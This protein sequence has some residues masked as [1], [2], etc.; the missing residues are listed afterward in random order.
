DFEL[1]L[2]FGD[3]RLGAAQHARDAVADEDL[4][5]PGRAPEQQVVERRDL[6]HLERSQ[7]AFGGREAHRLVVEVA[8]L[9]LERPQNVDDLLALEGLVIGAEDPELAH[10]STSPRTKS[11]PPIVRIRS[12]SSSPFD[13][14]SSDCMCTNDGVRTNSRYGRLLP[15]LT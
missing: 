7:I 14:C 2:Y 6:V 8:P 3:Q 4:A 13:R 5:P 10:L 9:L 1:T 15:L 11:M 12:E